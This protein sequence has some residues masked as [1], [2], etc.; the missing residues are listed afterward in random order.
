MT[1]K[2]CLSCA[3][4]SATRELGWPFQRQLSEGH[5]GVLCPWLCILTDA[6][7]GRRKGDL[8]QEYTSEVCR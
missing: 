5:R 3:W 2:K 8:C 1:W 7:G 4:H 6:N